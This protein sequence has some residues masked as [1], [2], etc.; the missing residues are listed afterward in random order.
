LANRDDITPIGT[1]QNHDA[2]Y[3]FDLV[4]SYAQ[5]RGWGWLDNEQAFTRISN[6]FDRTYSEA[7]GFRAPP[8]NF[9]AGIQMD[10]Q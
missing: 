3:R 6:L 9:V 10:L 1:I 2:Y 7:F 8:I 4:A 5:G